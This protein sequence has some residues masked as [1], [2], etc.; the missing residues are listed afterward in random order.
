M[1]VEL[2]ITGLGVI[3][4][5]EVVFGPGL[6]AVTGE[7]GAGKTM[8]MG[9]VDLL[10]GGRCDQSIVRTGA[11]AARAFAHAHELPLLGVNHCVAHLEIGLLEGATDPI[12]LYLSGGNTQV[13]GYAH[14]RYRVF[15]ETLDIGIG[16]MLDKFGREA[17]LEFPGGPKLEA[18]A[19]GP[20]LEPLPYSVKGMDMA[21][22]GLL[23]AALRKLAD[24]KEL[25]RLAYAI[26]ETAFAMACE[27]AERALAHT[28]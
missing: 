8:L 5:V 26:Q 2:R 17:G 12:L 25:P 23:P 10:L 7:T 11:T 18:L 4:E 9:A 14:S 22:S 13:I 16:N 3:D 1:L 24:G 27:V 21:F 6:T 28:G 20:E 15:G 19:A